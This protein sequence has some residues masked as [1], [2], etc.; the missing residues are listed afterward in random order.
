MVLE[1]CSGKMVVNIRDFG[2]II[3]QKEKENYTMPKGKYIK[4][5]G[6]KT[7]L[8][9]MVYTRI[10]MALDTRD[11]GKII[12]EKDRV[13]KY[14]ITDRNTMEC[15]CKIKRM[16]MDNYF[17]KMEVIIRGNFRE[18]NYMDKE[19]IIGKIKKHTRDHGKTT[20]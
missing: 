20:R 5:I 14:G 12:K 18:I 17:F 7:K 1:L 4:G 2:I 3:S 6:I 11:N 9:D 15:G 8:M 16:V 19:F 13:Y 10:M